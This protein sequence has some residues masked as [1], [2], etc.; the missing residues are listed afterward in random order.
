MH[1]DLFKIQIMRDWLALT[2]LTEFCNFLVLPNLYQRFVV[3][4]SCTTW[5]LR[6]VTK[7]GE[8]GKFF[9][10]ESQKKACIELK[11]EKLYLTKI[12][13]SWL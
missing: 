5:T 12:D 4:F 9:R 3:E 11:R 1:V 10:S 13:E 7:G 8:K 6:Q 2:T